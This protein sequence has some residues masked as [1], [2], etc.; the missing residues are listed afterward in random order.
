MRRIGETISGVTSRFRGS[1]LKARGTRGATILGVATVG[2]R[3]LRLVRNM[4]L[5]RILAP[6][7]FGTMAMVI[8]ASS[9]FEILGDVG[10]RQS[11]IHNKGGADVDYLNVA[12]WFQSLRGIGLY[13]VGTLAAPWVSRFYDMPELLPLLRVS[14]IA[15]IFNGF[16]SPRVFVLEKKLQFGRYVLL[17]Q[18]SGLLST[19]L[20][21]GLAFYLRNVWALVI[22]LV[23]E[24]V[25][26]CVLSFVLCPLLPKISIDMG[27][28]KELLNFAKGILGL[29]FL[30]VIVSQIPVIVLGKVVSGVQLGVYYMAFQLADQ[31]VQMFDRIVGRVILPAFAEKQDNKESICRALLAIARTTG[32]LGIPLLAF[33]VSCAGLILSV[34]YGSKYAEAAIPFSLLCVGG[35]IF[36]QAINLSSIFLGLG[37]PH[38][39]RRAVVLRGLLL[40]SLIYPCA[41]YWGL[42]GTAAAVLVAYSASLIVPLVWMRKLIGLDLIKYMQSWLPGLLLSGFVFLPTVLLNLTSLRCDGIN[43]VVGGLAYLVAVAIGAFYLNCRYKL[44]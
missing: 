22:G 38:L 14:F 21:I 10:V 17:T 19:L 35:L 34:V 8:S 6:D 18:G 7:A 13:L 26:R 1:S 32:V 41:V 28:L 9:I 37:L 24:T 39:Y 36:T 23:G 30:A 42:S 29:S 5:A 40:A 33:V 31:P 12:W 4:L 25:V 3:T 15:M 11:I 44:I 27:A 20:T 16:T 43:V 2:E